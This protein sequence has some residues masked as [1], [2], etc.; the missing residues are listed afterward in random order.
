LSCEV[1]H[2]QGLFEH[3]VSNFEEDK[4][5]DKAGREDSAW[6]GSSLEKFKWYDDSGEF[7]D[8]KTRGRDPSENALSQYIDNSK[9][10]SLCLL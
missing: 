1:G 2:I 9:S 3:E 6:V 10:H 5:V 7:E 8:W 4:E